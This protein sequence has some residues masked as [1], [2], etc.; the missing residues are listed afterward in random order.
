[1]NNLGYIICIHGKC[2]NETPCIAILN[3]QKCRFSKTENRNVN[4]VLPGGLV[5][6][7]GGGYKEREKEGECGGNIL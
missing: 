7:G 3:K 6:V 1:V 2:P 5:S 4:Q